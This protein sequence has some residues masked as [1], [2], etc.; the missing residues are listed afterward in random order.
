M[1]ARAAPV[2]QPLQ[3]AVGASL[4]AI[5]ESS[6]TAMLLGLTVQLAPEMVGPLQPAGELRGGARLCQHSPI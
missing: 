5:E 6:Q 2:P 3:V 4:A 1:P